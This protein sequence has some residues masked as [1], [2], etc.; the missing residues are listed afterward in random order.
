MK[1]ITMDLLN[2]HTVKAGDLV[3]LDGHIG[4][5]IGIDD[6]NVYVADTLYYWKGTWVTKFTYR[7]L[8]NSTFTHI[9]DMSELY[10]EDGNYTAMW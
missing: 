9:I 6:E 10:K 5:I 4:I 8:V 7:G 3:M 2:S 1:R